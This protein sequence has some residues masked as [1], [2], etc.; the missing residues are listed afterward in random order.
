MFKCFFRCSH[1]HFSSSSLTSAAPTTLLI[2]FRSVF[3]ALSLLW[4]LFCFFKQ[5]IIMTE[6]RIRGAAPVVTRPRTL[7]SFC[8]V[9]TECLRWILF[10]LF[11]LL[12]MTFC[13]IKL[14]F[15]PFSLALHPNDFLC[16][17]NP[18]KLKRLR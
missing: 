16:V 2:L 7:L 11:F 15:C 1:S 10:G 4:L 17:T 18:T 3:L 5:L 14:F 6:P 12:F 13:P 9:S 8:S